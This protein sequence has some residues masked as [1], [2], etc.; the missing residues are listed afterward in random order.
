MAFETTPLA[1]RQGARH[2]GVDKASVNTD[3]TSL[4]PGL[5]A[6]SGGLPRCGEERQCTRREP[7]GRGRIDILE[8]GA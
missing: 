2:K 6:G 3:D 5:Q 8:L 1:E 4:P 7:I